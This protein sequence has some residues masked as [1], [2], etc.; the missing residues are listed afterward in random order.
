MKTIQQWRPSMALVAVACV[1][2]ACEA[3][4]V[5]G[6][7]AMGT[8]DTAGTIG[9][10][11]D[12]TDAATSSDVTQ[13]SITAT[14]ATTGDA[15]ASDAA[16]P[17][18]PTV[19]D[20]SPA[21]APPDTPA[22]SCKGG[23][24]KACPGGFCATPEGQCGGAGECKAK[25]A[26]CPG[27]GTA[28]FVC[29]CDGKNYDSACFA[30][31]NSVAVAHKGEC[32]PIISEAC[33]VGA[34]GV[35][36]QEGE[37]CKLQAG[38]CAGKGKCVK[39]PEICTAI[40]APVCGCDGKT[41]SSDCNAAGA[42]QNFASK[43]EC[44]TVGPACS[45]GGNQCGDGKACYGEPS[46]CT[47]PG[48]CETKPQACTKEL[49]Q[50]CG[51]NG[52][53]Y[54]NPCMAKAAGVTVAKMGPCGT[55]PDKCKVGDPAGCGKG[56]YCAGPCGGGG[57]CKAKP[58]A[59]PDFY[60]LVCGCDGK[61]YG[62]SCGAASAGQNVASNGECAKLQWYT[63]CGD[64]VCK[65]W[66]PNPKIPPCTKEQAGDPCNQ[67]G[68]MCDPQDACN[69][70]L[71]CSSKDTKMSGCPISRA[72]FKSDIHYLTPN[73]VESLH[74]QVLA[75]RLATYRYKAAGAAAP[76]HL[77]FIIDDQKPGSPAVDEGR[78]MVEL[79]GYLSMSVAAI[80]EQA[81]RI[82]ALQAQVRALE[83][84]ATAPMCQ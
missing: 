76:R 66:T 18:V 81:K 4:P 74:D 46:Q 29:G 20:A 50:V 19:T 22:G 64:P 16:K 70:K 54:S 52:Q 71:V 56:E 43:G 14:D 2:S 65:G 35:A 25:P 39:K 60:K 40:Y 84:Q 45:V 6:G 73:D 57:A 78:D 44:G 31:K 30:A 67:D 49:N 51:C 21:D 53:T 77:G 8:A 59:C 24:P 15:G 38:Q 26:E 27:L 7:G 72:K 13:D 10:A 3:A 62:N 5:P 9:D 48:K 79:Y 75:T 61:T 47:G 32:K 11:A 63:T 23:D 36:C 58:D 69:S 12:A 82:E 28:I 1:V 83:R 17:D 37:Y 80:Q 68:Q 34:D 55:V 33:G 42:G 41:Y